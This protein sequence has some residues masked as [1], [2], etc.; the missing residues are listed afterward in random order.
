MIAGQKAQ[1]KPGEIV[2]VPDVGDSAWGLKLDQNETDYY[3]VY[4]FKGKDDVTI[5]TNGIGYDATVEIA[6]LAASRM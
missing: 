1:A 6:R 4:L 3:A 5:T 2:E